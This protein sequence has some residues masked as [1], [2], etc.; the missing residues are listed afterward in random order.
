MN[1]LFIKIL[2]RHSERFSNCVL[3][4]DLRAILGQITTPLL[5]GAFCCSA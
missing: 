2:I 4:Y 3:S 1:K 5:N